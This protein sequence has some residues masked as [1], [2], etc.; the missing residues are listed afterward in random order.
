MEWTTVIGWVCW[1]VVVGCA[2][3]ALVGWRR[4]MDNANELMALMQWQN[5]LIEEQQHRIDLLTK[6]LRAQGG[7]PPLERDVHI[8]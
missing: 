5:G 8:Q 6:L 7:D 2:T 4:A 3:I 1:L